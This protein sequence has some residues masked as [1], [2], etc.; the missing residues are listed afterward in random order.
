MDF[1]YF[2]SPWVLTVFLWEFLQYKGSLVV[3]S[4]CPSSADGWPK[5]AVPHSALR[6]T[7]EEWNVYCKPMFQM[8]YRYMLYLFHM[9]V[10][11]QCSI[12]CNGCTRMLQA[13]IINV[14]SVF[15]DVVASVYIWML[16]MIH[17]YVASVAFRCFKSRSGVTSPFLPCTAS[18]RRL[19]LLL[20]PTGHPNQRCRWAPPPPPSR[21]RWSL[22][23][24]GPCMSARNKVQ[25]RAFVRTS[26]RTAE[27]SMV[28]RQRQLANVVQ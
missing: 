16:Y 17:T 28:A 9:D 24:R 13:S 7:E 21:Y 18:P 5:R 4:M 2:C 27:T 11:L 26:S 1:C 6:C 15:L 25:A 3:T 22:R 8:F 23:R 10:R 12:C 14:S 19:L 20:K